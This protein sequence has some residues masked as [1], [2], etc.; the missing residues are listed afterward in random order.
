MRIL[1]IGA[2]AGDMDLTAGAVLAQHVLNHDEVT[3]VHLNPGE[4]GH[5]RLH[6]HEYAKQK[7]EE[8]TLFAQ[9]IGAHVRFLP[10][11]DGEL[12]VNSDTV[13]EMTDIIREIRPAVVITHWKQ[14]IHPDHAAAHYITEQALFYASLKWYERALP[15]HFVPYVYYADNWEDSEGFVPE[16]FVEI[17]PDAYELWLQAIS[18]Y[19]FARGEITRFP[20]ITYYQ[21]LMQVRGAPKG[22]NRAQAFMVPPGDL[23]RRVPHLGP[24]A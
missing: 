12:E 20:Y 18:H 9:H 11:H 3:L 5:P 2:H 21:A 8:A 6:P 16:V 4:K 10:Y 22:F 7:I 15:S 17:Q 13:H 24:Q 1:A 14:S 19:A 23:H